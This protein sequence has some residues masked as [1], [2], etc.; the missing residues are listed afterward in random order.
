MASTDLKT[1]AKMRL[2]GS[3][4]YLRN[5]YRLLRSALYDLVRYLKHSPLGG[6]PRS[7]RHY[8]A[9]VAMD[10]HR[11]EKG[12]ALRDSRPGFGQKPIQDLIYTLTH[13]RDRY[14]SRHASQVA[15]NTLASYQRQQS[16]EHKSPAIATFLEAWQRPAAPKNVCEGGVKNTSRAEIHAAAKQDLQDFFASRYSV[17][18]F[19]DEPVDVALI[20]EAVR[21]AQKTPSVCNRQAFHAH[22]L[23]QTDHIQ[24]ALAYQNGNR[25][26]NRQVDKLLIVT[27]DLRAFVSA[28][29]RNQCW[30]DGGMFAMS[31]VYALHSLGL[32]T[33][34][35]NWSVNWFTDKGLRKVV[36]LADHEAV[37]MMIAVGHLPEVFRVTHSPRLPLEATMTV[38]GAGETL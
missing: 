12:L 23:T 22:V 2:R 28:G 30:I 8:D 21:M 16:D 14:A 6:A 34:C 13:Y 3:Y 37:I 19:S 4:R 20:R 17:R 7:D 36:P 29:E 9:Y 5:L 11:L 18:D 25:G 10:Y 27:T 1:T 38:H 26:F 33:C 32:G 15:V 35:L 31:L 24:Q